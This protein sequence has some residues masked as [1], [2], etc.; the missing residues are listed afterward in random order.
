MVQTA[1]WPRSEARREEILSAASKV[2]R[3]R[4]LAG[5]GM[6]EIAAELGVAVGQLYYYFPG[7]A[8]LLRHCQE[9][10]LGILIAALET[11]RAR[12]G[13]AADRLEE[14]VE[15]HLRC[16]HVEVPGSLAHLGTE[17][18]PV[19]ARRRLRRLRQRY[20]EGV[21][22]LLQEGN[23]DGSLIVRDAITEAR[24]LLGALNWT[25]RWFPSRSGPDLSGLVLA[26]RSLL[27][28]RRAGSPPLPE[29]T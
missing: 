29:P 16:L 25:A 9:R 28:R 7:K 21:V 24:L 23:S 20:E 8:E 10:A 27:V 12:P 13:S 1:P 3:R 4:G 15:A 6:R 2:F 5:A 14:L 19:E 11:A 18:L 22:A 26:A 17:G